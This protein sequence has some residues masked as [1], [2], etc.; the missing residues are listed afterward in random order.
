M[1]N[2]AQANVHRLN[3]KAYSRYGSSTSLAFFM[4][5]LAGLHMLLVSAA[6]SGAVGRIFMALL[7]GLDMLLVGAA[8]GGSAGCIF[9]ALLA[10]LDMLL[11][12]A[13]S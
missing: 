11:V 8:L 4:A 13:A 2:V 9:I 10:S 6:L 12:R 5:L 1:V 3:K 7:A